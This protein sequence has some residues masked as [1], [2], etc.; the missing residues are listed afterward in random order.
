MQNFCVELAVAEKFLNAGQGLGFKRFIVVRYRTRINTEPYSEFTCG[1]FYFS[2][3]GDIHFLAE[4]VSE[5]HLYYTYAK[6]LRELG[7]SRAKSLD[8]T[9]I[10]RDDTNLSGIEKRL[11]LKLGIQ[12]NISDSLVSFFTNKAQLL[13]SKEVWEKKNTI[14]RGRSSIRSSSASS[15]SL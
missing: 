15:T 12:K 11:K 14:N 13:E 6:N 10:R 2:L 9:R 3:D 5:V 4:R 1:A 7:Y 8:Y